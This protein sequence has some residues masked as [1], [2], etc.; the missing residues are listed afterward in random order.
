[1]SRAM[2]QQE[3]VRKSDRWKH[4]WDNEY[5]DLE[6]KGNTI[7]GIPPAKL[8]LLKENTPLPSRASLAMS[9]PDARPA[10]SMHP[11][12]SNPKSLC[13]FWASPEIPTPTFVM[14]FWPSQL[15]SFG[16]TPQTATWSSKQVNPLP[17]GVCNVSAGGSARHKLAMQ[18]EDEMT[19]SSDSWSSS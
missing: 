17:G 14:H 13:S 8:H 9:L 3:C 5:S 2:V 10:M 15:A 19:H 7:C 18:L 1:M 16:R 11:L 6:T 4:F 12:T